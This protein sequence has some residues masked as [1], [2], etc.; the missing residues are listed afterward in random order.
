VFEP[1]SIHVG[2]VVDKIAL[3]Q[4]FLRI[5]L[6]SPVTFTPAMLHYMEKRKKPY[7]LQPKVA[8]EPQDC[9]ASVTSAAVLHKIGKD[10]K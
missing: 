1:V 10:I 3:A 7:H 2:L 9:G 8:N 6:F 5:L 4:V